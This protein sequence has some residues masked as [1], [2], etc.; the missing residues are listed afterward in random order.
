MAAALLSAPPPAHTVAPT[1]PQCESPCC[2]P[3]S[4]EI[5]PLSG[6]IAPLSSEIAPLS[7]EIAPLS[8]VGS[9]VRRHTGACARAGRLSSAPPDK[10]CLNPLRFALAN[11]VT[12]SSSVMTTVMMWWPAKSF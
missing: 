10:G 6:E 11:K 9:D 2:H 8:Q 12:R 1:W 4:G 7:G 5:A 3:S